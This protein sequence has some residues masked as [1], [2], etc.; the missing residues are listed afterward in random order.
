MLTVFES[1]RGRLAGG[2]S[3]RLWCPHPRQQAGWVLAAL[4]GPQRDQLGVGLV[5]LE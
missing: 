5:D 3:G 4:A 1:R 2:P